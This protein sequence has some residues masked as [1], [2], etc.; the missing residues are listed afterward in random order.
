MKTV[1]V[2]VFAAVCLFSAASAQT[3]CACE[4]VKVNDCAIWD[5]NDKT[6]LCSSTLVPCSPCAC[7]VGGSQKCQ[8][9]VGTSYQPIG[10]GVCELVK[11]EYAVCPEKIIIEEPVIVK[12]EVS[13]L[14]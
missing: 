13:K 7:V 14:G 3:E 10:K 8:V 6:G 11:T 4:R 5:I 9:E 12:G 2:V 1:A